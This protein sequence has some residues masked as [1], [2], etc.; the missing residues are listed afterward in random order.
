MEN[1]SF[2]SLNLVDVDFV[3]NEERTLAARQVRRHPEPQTLEFKTIPR[4]LRK[5]GTVEALISQNEDLMARLKVNIRRMTSLEDENRALQQDL[6]DLN[7]SYSSVSDQMLVW[8]EKE[9]I[10]KDRH[11]QL[12]NEVR[13]FQE[14]FPEYQRLEAQVE[15]LKRYQERVKSTIKPYLAQLKEY[16][17]SLHKQVQALNQELTVKEAQ[18]SNLDRQLQNQKEE[19]EQLARFYELNQNSLIEGFEKEKAAL[20]KE[21]QTLLESNQALEAKTQSLDRS[22]ERQDELENLVVSLR[23]NKEDFQKEVQAELEHLRNSSRELKAKITENQLT[24]GDLQAEREQLKAQTQAAI[25]AREEMDEQMTS[26][27]YM[28]TAKSEE[29]EKLKISIASLEKLNLELSSKLNDLR[30]Q[31]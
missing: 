13:V 23:R 7:L 30:K 21:V 24:I 3:E 27:R 31:S 29:N 5:S 12:E 8:R 25:S 17:Q 16:A 22:L 28:W 10:W 1:G 14:R 18:T 9:R 6:K 19:K 2:Q 4:D 20:N 15:R 11:K 26:L